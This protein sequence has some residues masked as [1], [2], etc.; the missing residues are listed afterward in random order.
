MKFLCPIC[1]GIVSAEGNLMGQQ[2]QCGHC[3]NTITVPDSRTAPGAVIG[4]FALQRELGVGGMGVVFLSHQ[5]SLDRPAALKLLSKTYA[6]NASFVEGFIKEARAAAKL[7]HPNIVQAY[8]VGED[9]GIFYFAMEYIDGMT[10]KEVL[11]KEK[12]LA[13]ERAISIIE[14]IVNALDYAWKEEKLIHR[15]IKP[16]NIML[17]TSGRAKLADLGLARMAGDQ[18]EAEGDTIMGTPQYI[19]PEHL[20]GEPMD[21]RS[22]L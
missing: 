2:V 8:A 4:D 1:Q 18:Q 12:I 16:D 11:A 3:S 15:D 13:P 9:E 22:D 14:Q 20:T 6:E 17:T 5:I 21:I 19:S 7:N 10:M